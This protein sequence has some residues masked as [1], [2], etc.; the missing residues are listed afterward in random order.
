MD[1]NESF[2][3]LKAF[4]ADAAQTAAKKAKSLAFIASSN[5]SIHAEMERQRK[6][7]HELG[8]LYYRDFIT[9]EEPDEAEYLPWCDK[10]TES[11]KKVE[12]LREAIQKER[13]AAP[14]LSD[15]EVADTEKAMDAELDDLEEELTEVE[16]AASEAVEEAAEAVAEVVEEA[17]EVDPKD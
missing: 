7:Y 4:A 14:D 11:L 3:N 5:I 8:K 1:L 10:L 17:A 15:E 2:E 16:E 9:A 6:Y 12:T 13:E